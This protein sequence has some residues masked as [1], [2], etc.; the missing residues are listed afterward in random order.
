M[1]E[2]GH[3]YIYNRDTDT[4]SSMREPY[5]ISD[6]GLFS[7]LTLLLSALTVLYK[8][9]GILPSNI[10]LSKA[11]C[12]FKTNPGEDLYHK[13]FTID[14]T[15]DIDRSKIFTVGPDYHHEVYDTRTISNLYCFIRRF[16]KLSYTT[17]QAVES[18]TQ[19][20]GVTEGNN[21]SVIFRGTDHF[22]DRGGMVAVNSIA[23]CNIIKQLITHQ[24]YNIFIQTDEPR[25][26][27]WYTNNLHAINFNETT[28]GKIDPLGPPV[29][30]DNLDMWVL[31]YVAALFIHSTSSK[32]FTYTGN[33]G[34]WAC[35]F[36][37]NLDGVYQDKTFSMNPEEFFNFK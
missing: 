27:Q 18:M 36:R 30:V 3:G 12:R 35:L 14:D 9:Y 15:V 5:N 17:Q 22:T 10:D 2:V 8:D 29:P 19:R 28:L 4:I 11:L 6:Y 24:H 37:G 7:T 16:F 34:L 26:N 33:S 21:I 25:V 20:Y 31:N 32:L 23:A 1:F 13:L